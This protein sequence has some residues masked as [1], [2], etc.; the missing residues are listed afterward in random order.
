MKGGFLG[1]FPSGYLIILL[2]LV[3]E[4]NEQMI[5]YLDSPNTTVPIASY[6]QKYKISAHI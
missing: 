1:K 5:T 2:Q 3:I 6:N 4:T